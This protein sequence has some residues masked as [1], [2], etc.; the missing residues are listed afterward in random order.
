MTAIQKGFEEAT[1]LRSN[2]GCL[3]ITWWEEGELVAEKRL[4]IRQY[5]ENHPDKTFRLS[6]TEAKKLAAIIGGA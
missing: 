5:M 3:L 6:L 2:S 1:V 4:C